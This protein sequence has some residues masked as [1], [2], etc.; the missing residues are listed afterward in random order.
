[1]TPDPIAEEAA[2]WRLRLESGTA[3]LGAFEAW[4]Q[5]DPRRRARFEDMQ[6]VWAF[7]DQVRDDP[8]M[9]RVRRDLRSRLFARRRRTFGVAASVAAGLAV[10]VLAAVAVHHA[11][12]ERV[13][14]APSHSRETI[15]LADGSTVLLDA[16]SRLRVRYTPGRRDLSLEEGQARFEV[17]HD[18]GRPFVV[19]AGPRQVVATGTVFDIDLQD[20]GVAVALLQGK[21]NISA[22][23]RDDSDR[24]VVDLRQGEEYRSRPGGGDVSRFDAVTVTAWETGRLVLNDLPLAEAVRRVNRYAER[25]VVLADTELANL[26]VSGVFNAGDAHAFAEAVTVLLPVSAQRRADGAIVLDPR[27][28][29]VDGAERPSHVP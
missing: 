28:A 4:L 9:H 18:A 26:R 3:D 6:S 7:F 5:A 1:M 19:Q 16:G 12:D 21:V 14:D 29:P 20:Q 24:S 8:G 13:Y 2:R 11:P 15:R 22:T 10:A 25:P 17:A 27:P 23:A